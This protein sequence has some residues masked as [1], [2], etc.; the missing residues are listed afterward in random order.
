MIPF[1]WVSASWRKPARRLSRLPPCLEPLET[2]VVPSGNTLATAVFLPIP[3]SGAVSATAYLAQPADVELYAVS[4]NRGDQVMAQ[5]DAQQMGMPCKARFASSAAAGPRS[6]W[7]TRKEEAP[8]SRFRR[9]RPARTSWASAPPAMTPTTRPRRTAAS[10][11]RPPGC[12]PWTCA[13]SRRRSFCPIWPGHGFE[14]EP[15]W[16]HGARPSR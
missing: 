2:R 13:S 8:A 14:W 6:R 10:A 1:A 5:V 7:T 16:P 4:L 11:E 9:R 15:S 3:P 12:S